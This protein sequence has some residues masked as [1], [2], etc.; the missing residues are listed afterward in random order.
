MDPVPV[1]VGA[2]V[3]LA[4]IVLGVR[5]RGEGGRAFAGAGVIA[6]APVIAVFTT[7]FVA[8]Q[9]IDVP[10]HQF[11]DWVLLAGVVAVPIGLLAARGGVASLAAVGLVAV[12]AAVLFAVP[13]ES[14]HERYWDGDVVLYVSILMAAVVGSFGARIAGAALGRSTEMLLAS[15]IAMLAAAPALGLSGTGTSALL[16]AAVSSSA[17]LFG[18]YL[19]ARKDVRETAS[20]L[21]RTMAA[22][23]AILFGGLLA[24]GVLYA[25]TPKAAGAMLIAAP[26]VALVPGKG[27]PASI[28]RLVIVVGI[29]ASAAWLSK[30][31]PDPYAGY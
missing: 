12:L 24:N 17:G 4:L 16:V 2:A 8:G 19:V 20:P 18:L 5:L 6:L 26:L 28:V 29:T 13:T 7:L 30:G 3:A 9:S 15:A 1:L 23:Q 22:P 25:E 11:L 31:E 21:D 27:L 14:L 10:P